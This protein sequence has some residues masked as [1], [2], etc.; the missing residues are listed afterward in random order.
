MATENVKILLRRGL[1]S[2]LTS[3]A[4]DPSEMGVTSD[5]NQVYV[6]T[7]NAIDE[8]IFDP[9]ANAHAVVQSWLDSPDNPEPGLFIEEDLVIRNVEDVD[10]LLLA[11][12]ETGPFNVSEYGRP[13]KHVEVLTENSYTQ[14]FTE[15]HLTSR[16]AITGRRPSLYM[17]TL[18]TTSGTFL[19]Y[20]RDICTTYF[21][22]YSLKQT[23]GVVTYVRVGTL[24]IINGAPHGIEQ[25]KLT[26]NNTEIWQDDS[27]GIAEADEFSNISFFATLDADNMYVS[28][29]QDADFTTEISY[30]IKR[31]SM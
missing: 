16:D 27:D 19:T 22:D 30:T 20:D 26:D 21:V 24:Q 12:F 18:D 28:Y 14:L 2:E 23:D 1:R 15:Q 9:F 5:T 8:I 6:G 4:L 7:E 29:T 3:A 11:M 25:V 13:R 10:A 31:W 17:K